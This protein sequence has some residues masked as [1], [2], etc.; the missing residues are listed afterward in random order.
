M[1]PFSYMLKQ[2]LLRLVQL[3]P[4][5][6]GMAPLEWVVLQGRDASL[7]ESSRPASHLKALLVLSVCMSADSY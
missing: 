1:Y 6:R 5:L 3:L 7:S 2:E 4:F